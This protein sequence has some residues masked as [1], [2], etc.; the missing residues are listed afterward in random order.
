MNLSALNHQRF[1]NLLQITQ[2]HMKATLLDKCIFF[3]QIS[4]YTLNDDKKWFTRSIS[5]LAKEAKISERSVSRYLKE[6]SEKG[7]IEKRSVLK[8]KK[9]LYIRITNRLLLLLNC[10]NNTENT[11]NLSQ[12]GVINNDSNALSIY[13]DNIVNTVNIN[14]SKQDNVINSSTLSSQKQ[15][16]ANKTKIINIERSSTSKKTIDYTSYIKG[17][18]NNLSVQNNLKISDPNQLMDEILFTLTNTENQ[19]SGIDD[20]LHRINIIAKLLREKRWRTPIGFYKHPDKPITSKQTNNALEI[21]S[22]QK[23][24]TINNQ[25]NNDKLINKI[26]VTSKS[27]EERIHRQRQESKIKEIDSDIQSQKRYLAQIDDW[28]SKSKSSSNDSLRNS[29]LLAIDNLREKKNH[30]KSVM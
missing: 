18:L 13:K 17:M 15:E 9:H 12:T 14:V 29:V 5:T 16:L 3:W 26:K 2:S 7:Y 28:K 27:H 19:L 30:I 23:I 4:T 25:T 6:F 11:S 20:P 21:S 1:D 24:K 22:K 8:L 10:N